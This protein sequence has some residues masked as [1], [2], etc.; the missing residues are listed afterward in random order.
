M[1][2]LKQEKFSVLKNSPKII[3]NSKNKKKKYWEVRRFKKMFQIWNEKH[4]KNHKNDSLNTAAK[5]LK[6]L[7]LYTTRDSP[8]N[9]FVLLN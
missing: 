6:I 7:S 5:T 4:L 8:I 3:G 9:Y 1:E 2:K